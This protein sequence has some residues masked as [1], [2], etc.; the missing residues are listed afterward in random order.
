MFS[1]CLYRATLYILCDVLSLLLQC[2]SVLSSVTLSVCLSVC[3]LL[4]YCIKRLQLL[5]KISHCWT[6]LDRSVK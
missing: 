5:L 2:L 3:Q 1:L 4:W 6:A